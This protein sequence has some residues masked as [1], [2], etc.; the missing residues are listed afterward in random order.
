M[1]GEV[2]I[3]REK[4]NGLHMWQW[5]WT[6]KGKGAVTVIKQTQNTGGNWPTANGTE[7]NN[8]LQIFVKFVKSIYFTDLQ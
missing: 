8:Y 2:I 6:N 4:E 7:V 3:T 5:Q 1:P